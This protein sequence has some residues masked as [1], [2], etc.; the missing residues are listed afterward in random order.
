MTTS[1]LL[2]IT[3]ISLRVIIPAIL[4]IALLIRAFII[5]LAQIPWSITIIIESVV[6]IPVGLTL[7]S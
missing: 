4:T 7:I 3:I 6:V 1:V 5:L 2:L